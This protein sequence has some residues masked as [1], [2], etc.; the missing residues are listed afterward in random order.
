MIHWEVH[1]LLCP[2]QFAASPFVTILGCFVS[3]PLSY[4]VSAYLS[5][6]IFC[7]PLV[8]PIESAVYNNT[9]S[10]C[11]KPLRDCIIKKA[12]RI[13]NKNEAFYS[14]LENYYDNPI[15]CH[16][17]ICLVPCRSVTMNPDFS[18]SKCIHST[19][20]SSTDCTEI[21]SNCFSER[22]LCIASFR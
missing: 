10:A 6:D 13:S 15:I 21:G 8:A 11:I 19:C 4:F 14:F 20:S 18:F 12:K 9:L 16:N 22:C 5:S 2:S 3:F 17:R 7:Q 1:T